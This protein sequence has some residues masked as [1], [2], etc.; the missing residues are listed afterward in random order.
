MCACV[1]W[2]Y[3]QRIFLF[4]FSNTAFHGWFS[5]DNKKLTWNKYFVFQIVGWQ[6]WWLRNHHNGTRNASNDD[7]RTS[8]YRTTSRTG[9][10]FKRCGRPIKSHVGHRCKKRGRY[11][12]HRALNEDDLIDG[13][14]QRKWITCIIRCDR[15][16]VCVCV[17][18]FSRA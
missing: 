9:A 7:S 8:R 4:W 1:T 2:K 12:N 5:F 10:Q 18:V 14:M 16:M 17:C 11:N 3:I 15:N 6:W 13:R